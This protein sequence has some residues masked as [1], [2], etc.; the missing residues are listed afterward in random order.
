M[1]KKTRL[2]MTLI[3][4]DTTTLVIFVRKKNH[5]KELQFLLHLLWQLLK[6]ISLIFLFFVYIKK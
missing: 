6:Q 5:L 3:T 4:L 2:E 1:K